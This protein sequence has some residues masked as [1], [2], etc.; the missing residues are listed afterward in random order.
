MNKIKTIFLFIKMF[1]RIFNKKSFKEFRKIRYAK[2]KG[3]YKHIDYLP[4]YNWFK[5]SE[6]LGYLH[7]KYNKEYPIFF[8]RIYEAMFYQFETID[9]SKL[10]QF[11]E[12]KYLKSLYATTKNVRYL[13]IHNTKEAA[14][15]AK[16]KKE[17]KKQSLN[18]LVTFV[19]EHNKAIGSIDVFKMSTS[20]FFNLYNR[21][22]EKVKNGNIK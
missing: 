21:T 8:K 18:D 3:Y 1:F 9:N 5:L 22:I 2:R 10:R 4:I 19:E 14:F 17:M 16:Q 20:R 7:K 12:L 13:N 6:N 15:I 11:A